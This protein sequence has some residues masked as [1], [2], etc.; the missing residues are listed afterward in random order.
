MCA[1][2]LLVKNQV[3]VRVWAYTWVFSFIPLVIVSV[4]MPASHCCIGVCLEYSLKSRT[5]LSP[6]FFFT[7]YCFYCLGSFCASIWNLRL[8][9]NF[10]EKWIGISLEIALDLQIAFGKHFCNFCNANPMASWHGTSPHVSYGA[11]F[12]WCLK[13]FTVQIFHLFG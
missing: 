9:F 5:V 11:F 1:F 13:V 7:W 6:T 3:A 12:L 10:C 4:L 2:G 8:F